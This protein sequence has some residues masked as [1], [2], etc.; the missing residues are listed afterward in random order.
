MCVYC[1]CVHVCSSRLLSIKGFPRVGEAARAVRALVGALAG[2]AQDLA[3][4]LL[5][6]MSTAFKLD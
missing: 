2:P 1:V 6:I 3:L 4:H 5:S